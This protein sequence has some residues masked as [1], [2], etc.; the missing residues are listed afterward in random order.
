MLLGKLVTSLS[1]KLYLAVLKS[2]AKPLHQVM[3]PPSVTTQLAPPEQ[4]KKASKKETLVQ[5]ITLNPDQLK[6]WAD[7]SATL[8][9]VATIHYIL[10]KI[11][12]GSSNMKAT[13][14]MFRVKLTGLRHCINGGKYVG[15]L[16]K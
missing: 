6:L 11:I 4:P 5:K 16:K 13:T 3:L 9:L 1:P 2:T 7:E 8:Y 15:G 14:A 10:K 12:M